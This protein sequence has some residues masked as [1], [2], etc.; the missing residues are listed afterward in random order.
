[1]GASKKVLEAH[2]NTINSMMNTAF[3]LNHNSHYGGWQLTNSGGSHIIQHRISYREMLAYLRGIKQG[4]SM[5]A[6][7]DG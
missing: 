5:E 1:M 2:L 6:G 7:Y 4:I 3:E